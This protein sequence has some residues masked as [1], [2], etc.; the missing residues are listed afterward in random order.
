METY[1]DA[2][3]DEQQQVMLADLERTLRVSR[4][5]LLAGRKEQSRAVRAGA[6]LQA[7]SEGAQ[8]R[9]D[10]GWQVRRPPADLTHRRV[11]LATA[12]TAEQAKGALASGADVW[13]ADLEDMLV[14]TSRRL[15][16]AQEVILEVAG[17]RTGDPDPGVPTLMVRPRGLH[18]DEAHLSVDD[19]PAG[20]SLVDT[21][22]FLARCG[23][24]LLDRGTGPYLY[25]PKVESAAEALW[26]DRML[27]AAEESLGLPPGCTRVSVLVETVQ[28]AYELDEIVHAL[29]ERVTGLAAGRWDYIF[30]HLRTYGDRPDHVLPDRDAFTMNTRFLR[31]YTDLIV[32]TCQRRGVQAIGGPIALAASGPFDDSVAMTHARVHRDK[33]REAKQGFD[34]AWVLHPALVPVA[35]QPFEERDRRRAQ[36]R[37]PASAPAATTSTGAGDGPQ[38]DAVALRDVSAIPGASTLT[39]VRTAMRSSLTYLTGWLAGEGTAT[40]AGHVEDFGTVELARM[41]LW[42][43]L[44]HG[45]RLAEGPTMSTLLLDRMLEDEVALLRRRGAREDLLEHAVRLLRDSVVAEEPPAFLSQRAYDVLLGIGEP[46]PETESEQQASGAA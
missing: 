38:P 42:Q 24:L 34:G 27:T 25:L 14:P 5:E 15:V 33:A 43:W 45:T 41:Q 22:T 21:V 18:L 8:V 32:R 26:W 12:A 20:A 11:E 30:S 37:G 19:R 35:R 1:P 16:A 36:G 28:A 3:L 6:E 29:R 23:Q 13:V 46:E 7:R 2:L 4:A 40:L 9:A 17:T 10:G 39:G 44:T 31:T